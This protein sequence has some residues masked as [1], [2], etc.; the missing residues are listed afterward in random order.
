MQNT[1]YKR[2][3]FIFSALVCSMMGIQTDVSQLSEPLCHR[4][5]VLKQE[6][7]NGHHVVEII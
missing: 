5:L 1:S 3:F 7:L 2:L 4:R 6:Y